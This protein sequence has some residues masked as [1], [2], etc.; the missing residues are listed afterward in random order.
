M[1]KMFKKNKGKN[2]NKEIQTAN[3]IFTN[4][5]SNTNL[6]T[7]EYL[8]LYYKN[9]SILA[10]GFIKTHQIDALEKLTFLMSC[11]EKEKQAISLGINKYIFRDDIEEFLDRRE[12]QSANIKIIELEDYPRV[13]PK[14]IV[15]KIE[16]SK[17]I[18][19]KMYIL[20][21]DYTNTTTKEY[22]RN[23]NVTKDKDP[24]LFGT[25]Q[26]FETNKSNGNFIMNPNTRRR[27]INDKFY[28]IGD[29]VDE[30]C[31]LT[32]DK[33]VSMTSEDIV[34]DIDIPL[35]IDDINE[36]LRKLKEREDE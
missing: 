9:A 18:F 8:D 25:F 26:K 36:E 29:W 19:D 15:D 33:L 23:K 28:V 14:D 5:K 31:D 3:E 32:L 1:L 17:N 21:T 6:S 10:E 20:F 22:L 7:E 11:V 4:L 34:K 16:Q 35:S 27:F 30:Y 24:I 12:I 13:I 2:K